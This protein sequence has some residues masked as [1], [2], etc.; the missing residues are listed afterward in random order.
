M[1]IPYISIGSL[2]SRYPWFSLMVIIRV[3]KRYNSWDD[4]PIIQCP[5]G[6]LQ[7]LG[8]WWDGREPMEDENEPIYSPKGFTKPGS[9]AG[10]LLDLRWPRWNFLVVLFLMYCL[11]WWHSTTNHTPLLCRSQRA[12]HSSESCRSFGPRKPSQAPHGLSL[13]IWEWL[14]LLYCIVCQ[15]LPH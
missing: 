1:V 15:C 4:P 6:T 7:V 9:L 14:K 13:P 10:L 11:R 12:L 8:I 3:T 2:L 5:D